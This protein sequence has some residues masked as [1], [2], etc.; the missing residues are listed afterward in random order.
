MCEFWYDII[1]QNYAEKKLCYMDTDNFT[2]HVKTYGIYKN[3]AEDV[4]TRFEQ[5]MKQIDRCLC[6]KKNK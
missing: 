3:I 1:E 5:I 4:K 2:V 6:L